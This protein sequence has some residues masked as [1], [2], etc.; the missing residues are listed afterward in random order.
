MTRLR[1]SDW[2]SIAEVVGALAVVISL[3]YVGIQIN[4][5]TIEVRA[6]NRQELVNR[7]FTATSNAASS[8]E[9]AGALAK[10]A[11]GAPLS[12]QELSQYRYF[13]RSMLYDVQ[14]AYLLFNEG[15]LDETYWSTRA[16]IF[17]A[18][19]ANKLAFEVYRRDKM[20]GVL[21]DDFVKWVDQVTEK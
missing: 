1:L 16:A 10:A 19:I 4:A 20:L 15:R 6:A 9:L 7:S 5:N 17:E 2:A 14:E 11:E 3:L 12:P 8:P 21:H 13:V 18:Y